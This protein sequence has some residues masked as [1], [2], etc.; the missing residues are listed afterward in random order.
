W[1]AVGR[2]ASAGVGR[3]GSLCMTPDRSPFGRLVRGSL[4]RGLE[5]RLD[6]G[7]SIESLRSGQFV[8]LHGQQNEFF[9]MIT[10]LGLGSVSNDPL[11]APPP[12]D[13]LAQM[14][15]GTTLYGLAT[16]RASLML[17]RG[18]FDGT[19]EP[20]PAKTVPGHFSLAYTASAGDVARIF[21]Q[22]KPGDYRYFA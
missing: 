21:G 13:Q 8:V 11:D 14:I 17:P 20:E 1:Q 6:D 19:G 5:V 12:A 9:G 16:V 10:D 3:P 7:Q 4:S 18:L 2:R 22:E 15:H